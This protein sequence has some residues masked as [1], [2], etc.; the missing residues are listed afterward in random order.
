M[1]LPPPFFSFC[2]MQLEPEPE[3]EPEVVH[4]SSAAVGNWLLLIAGLSICWVVLEV[5][6]DRLIGDGEVLWSGAEVQ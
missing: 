1:A 6:P 5:P 3:P 2:G 4:G